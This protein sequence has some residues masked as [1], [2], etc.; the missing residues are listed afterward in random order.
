MKG[1]YLETQIL[2]LGTL[3]EVQ[4]L[5]SLYYYDEECSI[6]QLNLSLKYLSPSV[7]S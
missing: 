5:M 4:S 1:K 6:Y 2:A 3:F 7:Y